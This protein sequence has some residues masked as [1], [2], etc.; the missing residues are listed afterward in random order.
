MLSWYI[1]QFPLVELNYTYYRL[2]TAAQL[3]KLAAQT[4]DGFQFLVKL[5]ATLTHKR[6]PNDLPLFRKAVEPLHERGQLLGLLGQFPQSWHHGKEAKTW[7]AT[8]SDNFGD[9]HLAIEFRHRSWFRDDVPLWL[10]E[11][12]LDLVSVDVPDLP[13]LYPR[14]LVQ[15][16]ERVY[17]RF[18]S[19]NAENWYRSG[20]ERYDYDY[21]DDEMQE[22]IDAL[23]RLPS[24]ATL[25]LLFN[26]CRDAHAVRNAQ[27][28]RELLLSRMQR[29][30]VVEPPAAAQRS[31]FE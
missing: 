21:S 4:P 29:Q 17:I 27:R 5:P 23:E 18:H 30:R 20:A 16:G 10:R 19:R 3:T 1:Q 22:W 28:M 12:H 25:L 26:N 8:L 6:Q 24:I 7:L 14:G 31:L 9:L 13:G 15:S 11:H 2:P